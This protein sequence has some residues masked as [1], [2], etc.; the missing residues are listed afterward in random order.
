MKNPTTD[1]PKVPVFGEDNF[2]GSAQSDTQSAIDEVVFLAPVDE[3][4]E[5]SKRSS[6][7]DEV[8]FLEP[9]SDVSEQS[10]KSSIKDEV[11]FLN[12]TDAVENKVAATLDQPT[13]D[14]ANSSSKEEVVF[15]TP[16]KESL[17]PSSEDDFNISLDK[18]ITI[19]SIDDFE[20][21]LNFDIAITKEVIFDGSEVEIIDT[22]GLQVLVGVVNKAKAGGKKVVWSGVSDE[23]K[24]LSSVLALDGHLGL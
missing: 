18:K 24:E 4:L 2:D 11:V 3:A 21:S 20:S 7:K 22:A 19:K 6:I 9:S 13:T 5:Q 12:P 16:Q 23:L 8:V 15:L 14:A 1:L 17:Q 10:K